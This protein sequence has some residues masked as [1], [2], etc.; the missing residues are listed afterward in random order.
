M[1]YQKH[2]DATQSRAIRHRTGY[3]AT[4]V[5]DLKLPALSGCE[6]PRTPNNLLKS[7]LSLVKESNTSGGR[8]SLMES[9]LASATPVHGQSSRIQEPA[10]ACAATSA[11]LK[12]KCRPNNSGAG[13]IVPVEAYTLLGNWERGH[14]GR[15]RSH[16]VRGRAVEAVQAP[17]VVSQSCNCV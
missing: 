8:W 17:C 5:L 9:I 4:R 13:P 10:T 3:L 7:S 12:K 1:L 15:P 14:H 2:S 11:A 6:S 16:V